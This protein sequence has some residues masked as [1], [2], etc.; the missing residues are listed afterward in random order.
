MKIV[1]PIKWVIRNSDCLRS[2]DKLNKS[3]SV[4][5]ENVKIPFNYILS[6]LKLEVLV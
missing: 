1:I 6:F 5:T 3:K 4:K 2:V